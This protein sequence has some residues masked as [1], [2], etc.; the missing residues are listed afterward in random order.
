MSALL[1]YKYIKIVLLD[2]Y[3]EVRLT[4]P[5]LVSRNEPCQID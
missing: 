4:S 2:H 1:E 5:C 3:R